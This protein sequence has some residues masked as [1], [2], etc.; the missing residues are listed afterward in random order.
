MYV[1]LDTGDSAIGSGRRYCVVTE[2]RKWVHIYYPPTCTG[3]KVT[4]N[5]YAAF[6]PHVLTPGSDYKPK[7]VR[8]RIRERCKAYE[9]MGIG[10]RVN[11]GA[12]K[13]ALD[14]LRA[15]K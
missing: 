9:G 5:Q 2:G 3:F 14:T 12:A 7:G 6:R 1:I 8:K 10:S 11:E 15:L 13:R 4:K